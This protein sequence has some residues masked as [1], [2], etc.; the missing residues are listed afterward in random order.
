MAALL[1]SGVSAS[2]L[3]FLNVMVFAEGAES[4]VV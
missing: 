4:F 2:I 3:V 1:R